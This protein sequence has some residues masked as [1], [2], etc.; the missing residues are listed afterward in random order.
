MCGRRKG[1][2]KEE[3]KEAWE[4]ETKCNNNNTCSHKIKKMVFSFCRMRAMVQGQ[5]I[6]QE[7]LNGKCS[8][9][10]S[11]LHNSV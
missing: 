10:F 1:S 9:R 5:T 3:E 2:T 7:E 11:E 4:K 8:V 6:C